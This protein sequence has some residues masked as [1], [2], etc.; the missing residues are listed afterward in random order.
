[1]NYLTIKSISNIDDEYES[2]QIL[3][4]KGCFEYHPDRANSN[5]LSV[6]KDYNAS[7]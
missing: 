5:I 7:I 4:N 1:M 3:L 2:F 6:V